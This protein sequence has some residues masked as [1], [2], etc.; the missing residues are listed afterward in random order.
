MLYTR[1][2]TPA[3]LPRNG[4]LLVIELRAELSRSFGGAFAGDRFRPSTN[5]HAP[6]IPRA[7]TY[8]MPV[9]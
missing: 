1:A 6:P 5:P 4:P 8:V 2:K 9:P 3:E 7:V